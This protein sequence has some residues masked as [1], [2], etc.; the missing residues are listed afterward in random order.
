VDPSLVLIVQET[1]GDGES[2]PGQGPLLGPVTTA[3][4]TRLPFGGA[5][6]DGVVL[7]LTATFGNAPPSVTVLEPEKPLG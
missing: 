3:V 6:P 4:N 1:F 5:A 2:E 7:T